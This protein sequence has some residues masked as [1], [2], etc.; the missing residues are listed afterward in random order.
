MPAKRKKRGD[1]RFEDALATVRRAF[2]ETGVRWM[3]IGGIAAIARGVRRT[4]TDIDVAVEGEAIAVDAL[5][6]VLAAHDLRPRFS[7]AVKF[8]KQNLVLLVRDGENE[9][10]VDISLAYTAF[11]KE[12]LADAEVTAFG[13]ATVPMAR[14]EDLVIFKAVAGRPKDIEDAAGLLAVHRDIDVSRV[15]AKLR[16]LAEVADD[17]KIVDV[18]E[19]ILA[20]VRTARRKR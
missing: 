8:A 5:V 3:V 20:R 1:R 13:R 7:D 16:E 11:E 10:D 12:A 9:I 17:P 4:T 15:R 14:A 19:Q 18:L 6:R 2:D